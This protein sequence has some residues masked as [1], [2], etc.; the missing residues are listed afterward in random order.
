MS[1]MTRAVAVAA[2]AFL[3]P[4]TLFAQSSRDD[5]PPPAGVAYID[6]AVVS[7]KDYVQL[8]AMQEGAV[9]SL[10]LPDGTELAEGIEVR[11]GELLG[12]LDQRD[13]EARLSASQS[14]Y[15]VAK[16][17]YHK[18]VYALAAAEKTV[19]V[20]ESEY[21]ESMDVNT[22][23]P[24]TIPETQVRRQLLTFQRSEIEVDVSKQ[25]MESALK[26][27]HL[28]KQ[29]L[30]IAQINLD[31][32]QFRSPIDGEVVQVFRKVGEWLKPGETL[33][34][35][36]HLQNLRIEGFLKVSDYLPQDVKGQPVTVTVSR[37]GRKETFETTISYVSPLVQ[38]SGDFRVVCEVQNKKENGQ[39]VLLPGMDAEM[40]IQLRGDQLAHSR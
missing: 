14:E 8:P 38:A 12:S 16:V 18:A 20:A 11:K 21:Q 4:L 13:A 27:A 10:E 39:W 2:T 26:T 17:E 25:E 34:R 28:R 40:M 19:L 23:L 9:K 31:H 6:H 7:L 30:A 1:A 35:I 37:A 36:I 3:A 5:A 32:H 15:E 29:Q 33:V 22:R 24:G